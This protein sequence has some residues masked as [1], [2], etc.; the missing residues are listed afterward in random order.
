MICI[1][2][3]KNL[4]ITTRSNVLEIS[5][6][7]FSPPRKTDVVDFVNDQYLN[8]IR[9]SWLLNRYPDACS[10]C[11]QAEELSINSRRIGSNQWYQDHNCFNNTVELIRIDYWVGDL[12]NLKCVICG[13]ENS[14][15]WK[16]ELNLPVEIKRTVNNQ[17][18]KTMDLTSVKFIHFNGGEPLLNKEHIELLTSLDNKQ[19]IQLNYNT[20]A[21]VIPSAELL[22]L[23][24]KF[25][26]VQLD[27]SIDDIEERFEYQRFPASW[28]EVTKNLQWYFNHAPTNC[29]FS[30]NTSVSILNYYN[31]DNLK[32][33][34]RDNFSTNRLTDPIE[35]R[36]QMVT[37]LFSVDNVAQRKDKIVE[38]LN[39]LDKKRG[40]N[41]RQ[42][43]PELSKNI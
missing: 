4:S 31:L 9:N 11:K 15:S 25:D 32:R 20:N 27:F 1:D 24:S 30:V 8:Q 6:C 10:A 22:E 12:C 14:S 19:Q 21:T 29:M 38:F 36:Q 3:F 23:W 40:T 41:W 2:A 26:L 42:T 33:W 37:G 18:W 34:L 17:F 43:L 5:P 13:P 16:Q 35:H 39:D 28:D 7:C